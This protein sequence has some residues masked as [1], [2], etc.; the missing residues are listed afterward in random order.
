MKKLFRKTEA[1][2]ILLSLLCLVAYSPNSIAFNQSQ[3]T[4]KLTIFVDD[5]AISPGHG[6]EDAPYSMIR[7][8]IENASID[9]DIKIASGN[10]YENL[11]VD[12]E[13]LS[14]AWHGSD[15]NGTDQGIPI[16]DGGGTGI[17]ILVRNEEVQISNLRIINSGKT[18]LDAGIYIGKESVEVTIS[19]CEIFDCFYG[20]WAKRIYPEQT[21]HVITN[22]LIENMDCTGIYLMFSDSNSIYENIVRNCS[23]HGIH[24]MDGNENRL[25]DN[26]CE[27]NEFGITIDVGLENEVEH[28]TCKDNTNWGFIVIHTIKTVITDNNFYD[29]GVGQATWINCILDKWYHNYWGKKLYIIHIV[30]GQLRGADLSV[31]FIKIELM[32]AASPN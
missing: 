29:N 7:Y 24:I 18:D 19:D 13:K 16:I 27:Y 11:V 32:P 23:R 31:P 9:D 30:F 4:T 20:I 3:N 25:R 10:Y 12:I 26:I 1:I 2:V 8:A 5:D 28:N 21:D 15:I 22:N 14:L 6:T 17:V